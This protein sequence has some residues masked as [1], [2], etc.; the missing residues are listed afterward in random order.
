MTC[1]PSDN[2]G[3]TDEI[4]NEIWFRAKRAVGLSDDISLAINHRSIL[5]EAKKVFAEIAFGHPHYASNKEIAY[6]TG[7]DHSTVSV[8]RTK[9]LKQQR[10]ER[11]QPQW[12]F[13]STRQGFGEQSQS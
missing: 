13:K 10:S 1:H 2:V 8:C 12:E 9:W 6:F 4:A 5:I 3:L 11:R 7:L